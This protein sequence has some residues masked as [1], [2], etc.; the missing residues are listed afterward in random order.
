MGLTNGGL[1]GRSKRAIL[2]PSLG[3]VPLGDIRAQK[4]RRNQMGKWVSKGFSKT[5]AFPLSD[6]EDRKV[7]SRSVSFGFGDF[8]HVRYKI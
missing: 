7:S 3:K 2:V 8:I 4:V 1:W 5:L 6:T